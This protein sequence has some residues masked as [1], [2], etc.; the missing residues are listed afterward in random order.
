M[1]VVY[2][3]Y[4]AKHN[5]IYVGCTSNLEERLLSHNKLGKKGWTINYRPWTLVYFEQYGT[6]ELA[7]NRERE[8][9]FARGRAWI[10]SEIV[11]KLDD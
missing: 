4:S 11:A 5:K 6:K 2:V 8:L 3:L 10:W 1:Y 7:M 9:K